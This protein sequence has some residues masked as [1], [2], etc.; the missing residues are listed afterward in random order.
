MHR[1]EPGHYAC[2]GE[3]PIASRIRLACVDRTTLRTSSLL[4]RPLY[5]GGEKSPKEHPTRN[6][7]DRSTYVSICLS[8]LAS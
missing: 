2:L 6:E 8:A 1:A 7:T 5:I 4:V 3:E